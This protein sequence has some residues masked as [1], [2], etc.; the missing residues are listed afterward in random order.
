MQ[1]YIEYIEVT[2]IENQALD[3]GKVT[4]SERV[5]GTTN[6]FVVRYMEHISTACPSTQNSSK[7]F[8]IDT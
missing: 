6:E 3:F 7:C 8:D 1:R 5:F 2:D 4:L